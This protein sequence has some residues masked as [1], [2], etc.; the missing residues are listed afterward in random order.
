MAILDFN[1]PNLMTDGWSVD[2]HKALKDGRIFVQ[3]MKF[4][5]KDDAF[6]YYEHIRKMWQNQKQRS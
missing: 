3:K 4:E 2:V 5:N 6:K 1:F